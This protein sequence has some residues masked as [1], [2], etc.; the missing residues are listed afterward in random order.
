MTEK[1]RRKFEELIEKQKDYFIRN[2]SKF[3]D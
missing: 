1:E 3:I 2:L